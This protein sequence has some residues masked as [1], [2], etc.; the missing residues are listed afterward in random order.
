MTSLCPLVDARG[1][2]RETGMAFVRIR[3]FTGWT[4]LGRSLYIV[5]PATS[6]ARIPWPTRPRLHNF[7][8]ASLSE[9]GEAI[10]FYRRHS[11]S[12]GGHRLEAPMAD[13]AA[14][15][16]RGRDHHAWARNPVGMNR[17]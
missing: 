13:H 2:S 14:R 17:R 3:T 5:P 15:S 16:H 6:S 10:E 12:E 11:E 8:A 7:H 9:T 1:A 4:S